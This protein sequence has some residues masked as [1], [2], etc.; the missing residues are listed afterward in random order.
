MASVR[1][2]TAYSDLSPRNASNIRDHTI[3]QMHR[4]AEVAR[5]MR[6]LKIPSFPCVW[7]DLEPWLE[8]LT[9]MTTLFPQLCLLYVIDDG[10]C[11]KM[12]QGTT[13]TY[14]SLNEAYE[15]IYGVGTEQL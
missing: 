15:S 11:M 4:D 12:E 1:M 10:I 7:S 14:S 13:T 3:V 6:T 9:N 8:G 2:F 5:V